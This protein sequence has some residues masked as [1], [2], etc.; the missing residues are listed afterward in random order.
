MR[1]HSLQMATKLEVWETNYRKGDLR[2]EDNDKE[3]GSETT[4]KIKWIEKLS[5]ER[6]IDLLNQ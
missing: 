4:I 1:A 6:V 2:C 5:E 3:G